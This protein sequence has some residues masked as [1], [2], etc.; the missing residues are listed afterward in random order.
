MQRTI[1]L[2]LI[3][4]LLLILMGCDGII[5]DADGRGSL[6]P[7]PGSSIPPSTEPGKSQSALSCRPED[8][9]KVTRTPLRR[10]TGRQYD[11]TVRDLL[12]VELGLGANFPRDDY[13]GPFPANSISAVSDSHVRRYHSA[14]QENVAALIAK[15][16]LGGIV[17]CDLGRGD[18]ACAEAFIRQFGKRAFRRPL[19]DEQVARLRK[20][21]DT[22]MTAGG[23][24]NGIRLTLEAMLQSPSFLYHV[25]FELPTSSDEPMI[26]LDPYELASRLSYFL[27]DSMPDEALIAAAESGSLATAA[28][29]RAQA[30]R[31]LADRKAETALRSFASNWLNIASVRL[32]NRDPAKFPMFTPELGPAMERETMKFVDYVVRRGDG[33][34]ASLLTAP[35]SFPEGGTWDVYGVPKPAGYDG[36]SPVDLPNR[37]GVL[38]QPSVLA[39]QSAP[40]HSH[41]IKRG[42]FILSNLLCT[43]LH[44]PEGLEFPTLPEPKPNQT[45]REQF[46]AHTKDPGC[47]GCHRIIDPIG[48]TLERY[49]PV[50][51]YRET[52]QG[53]PIDVTGSLEIADQDIAGPLTGP[54]DLAWKIAT[55]ETGRRCLVRQWLRFALGRD[56]AANDTCSIDALLHDFRDDDS[57]RA[58]ILN[59][60][61]QDA[62]RFRPNRG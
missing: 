53:V 35:Y 56:Q 2:Y 61:M 37:L 3:G 57:V 23:F 28:G 30:E 39:A 29:L 13:V 27:W 36:R 16:G 12:G 55:S 18:A 48:F 24:Q 9:N 10:M 51:A 42:V 47:A 58:L 49:D 52:D 43:D 1:L 45:T 38:T 20:V 15:N 40:H 19:D 31:M 32:L 7:T 11:A 25:E 50:G 41:P 26:M 33:L 34:F 62:F 60:V 22:G 8:A 54:E 44:P 21:F 59:F 6:P 17:P 4:L 46:E 5:H 14:A